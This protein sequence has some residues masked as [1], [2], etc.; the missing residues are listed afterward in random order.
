LQK[1]IFIMNQ[2]NLGKKITELRKSQG[3]TQKEL[4]DKCNLN[5]RTLQRI[6]SG[7]VTPRGYTLKLVLTTLNYQGE[8]LSLKKSTL[9]YWIEKTF[10]FNNKVA[11]ILF[12][13]LI[14][15]SIASAFYFYSNDKRSSNIGVENKIESSRKEITNWV[16]EGNIDAIISKFSNDACISTNT[17]C[18]KKRIKEAL[19]KNMLHGYKIIKH[20]IISIQSKND[21]AFEKYI[22]TYKYKG[23]IH[24][25]NGIT[26]WH[27]SDGEWIISNEL[28]TN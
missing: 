5:I 22:A 15:S 18:G 4:V 17:I 11:K 26:E 10:P 23:T 24:E 8:D 13:L 2:P 6:E 27:F 16:N 14:I 12:S 19:K 1:N 3:L 7:E 9:Y 25:Q 28:Y 20:D 21:I